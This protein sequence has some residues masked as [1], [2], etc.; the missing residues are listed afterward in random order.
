MSATERAR[1]G[2][3]PAAALAAAAS[4]FEQANAGGFYSVECRG[5]DGALKWR[6]T[7]HNLWCSEGMEAVLT[8]ALKGSAYTAANYLGLITSTNYTAVAR[9]NT[10]ANITTASGSPANGW[11]EAPSSVATPRGTP[12][13]GTASSS[14]TNT[15][16]AT[17]SSVSFSILASAT[18]KGCFLLV[19]SAAGTAPTS[20][21]G[22]TSGAILSAGLFTGGDKVVASSDTLNVTYTGRLTT[23]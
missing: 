1:A 15:D 5:A 18:I 16:L 8:H 7:V 14:G 23:T 17:S 22:N 2:D 19:R 11:N 13:F 3:L 10:A 21:V 9:T 12:S 4:L 20:A 6:D